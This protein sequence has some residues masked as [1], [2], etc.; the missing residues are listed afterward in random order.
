MVV[1]VL[2]DREAR[3][4]TLDADPAHGVLREPLL[5]VHHVL[6]A[7][8]FTSTDGREIELLSIEQDIGMAAHRSPIASSASTSLTSHRAA[9]W[10]TRGCTRPRRTSPRRPF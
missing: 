6:R 4:T 10:P 1:A 2:S 3:A 5:L 7:L 8:E 9:R